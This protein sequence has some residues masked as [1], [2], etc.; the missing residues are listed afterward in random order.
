MKNGE[1]IV[2]IRLENRNIVLG[3]SSGKVVLKGANM[4]ILVQEVQRIWE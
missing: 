4:E 1:E 3:T 2:F